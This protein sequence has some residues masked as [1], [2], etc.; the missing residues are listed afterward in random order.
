[1]EDSIF[2]TGTFFGVE[3]LREVVVQEWTKMIIGSDH[4]MDQLSG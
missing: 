2:E 1:M 3:T 4:C